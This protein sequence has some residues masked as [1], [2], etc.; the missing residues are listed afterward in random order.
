LVVK[1][2]SL[3]SR[4][5]GRKRNEKNRARDKRFITELLDLVIPSSQKTNLHGEK[6][7]KENFYFE[8]ALIGSKPDSL[9]RPKNSKSSNQ[10]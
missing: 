6:R 10:E 5:K 9:N 1:R 4:N 8:G 7:K 3:A 2:K